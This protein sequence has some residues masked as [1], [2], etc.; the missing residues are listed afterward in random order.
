[1]RSR[2]PFLIIS[3]AVT[4]L[5]LLTGAKIAPGPDLAGIVLA[6]LSISV[7]P[8]VLIN[9]LLRIRIITSLKSICSLIATGLIYPVLL[10]STGF[11]PGM[12]LGRISV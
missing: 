12:G 3:S 5:S 9:W 7:I 6:F 10:V 11:I 8:A 1:M 2:T 4:V